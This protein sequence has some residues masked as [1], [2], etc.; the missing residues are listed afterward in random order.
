MSAIEELTPRERRRGERLRPSTAI[1]VTIGR[2]T[3]A[4]ID[5]SRGGMRVRH[6][7]AAMRGAQVRIA[8]EW[9]HERFETLA[10][11]LASRVAM[12]GNSAGAPTMFDT[13][14]R[15]AKMSDDARE[16]LDRVLNAIK[17]CELRQWVSNLR[18]WTDDIRI[19]GAGDANGA[20]LRCRFIGIRWKNMLTHDPTQPSN[21]FLLPATVTPYDVETLCETYRHADADGRHLIRLMAEE[22]VREVM[23]L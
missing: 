11:V 6:A 20:F 14:L 23:D 22:A 17:R 8:F 9:Q 5:V 13:R 16:I 10:E 3:G 12:L 7:V 19:D 21:G 2:A 15:F 4:V 18:G 1:R